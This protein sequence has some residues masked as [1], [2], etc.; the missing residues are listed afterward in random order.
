VATLGVAETNH[1]L[2]SLCVVDGAP[3][4]DMTSMYCLKIHFS[5]FFIIFRNGGCN[6][7]FGNLKGAEKKPDEPTENMKRA[8]K[9]TGP[10]LEGV[11]L[12]HGPVSAFGN[13]S[14]DGACEKTV[15]RYKEHRISTV[16]AL[17]DDKLLHE[18]DVIACEPDTPDLLQQEV[19]VVL[20]GCLH[21]TCRMYNYKLVP[22]FNNSKHDARYLHAGRFSLVWN[23]GTYFQPNEQPLVSSDKCIRQN[24]TLVQ[25]MFAS[26][27]H[28]AVWV[29]NLAVC[30]GRM[31]FDTFKTCVID[32]CLASNGKRLPRVVTMLCVCFASREDAM[33]I[34][35]AVWE[36]SPQTRFRFESCRVQSQ[37][38]GSA[39]DALGHVRFL[40]HEDPRLVVSHEEDATTAETFEAY[41][42]A[43]R[44]RRADLQILEN[45]IAEAQKQLHSLQGSYDRLRKTDITV[46]VRRHSFA[47]SPDARF[48]DALPKLTHLPPDALDIILSSLPG[49]HNPM[50]HNVSRDLHH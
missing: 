26:Q 9:I 14:D 28:D 20:I 3:P 46:T 5:E 32:P 8:K 43:H 21:R 36:H 7:F 35:Q 11:L 50:L 17:I 19:G 42:V 25:Q 47:I 38:V 31:D 34:T 30:L 44:D 29:W 15:G 48:S 4:T 49:N 16:Q 23:I 22:C 13:S 10:L 2:P 40:G 24:A 1:R 18:D 39:T 33:R 37:S 12:P 41:S 6:R 27:T 45:K